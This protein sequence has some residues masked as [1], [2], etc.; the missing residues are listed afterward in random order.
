M[1]VAFGVK[2]GLGGVTWKPRVEGWV[3]EPVGRKG[4]GRAGNR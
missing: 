4:R 3:L 2:D 1:F